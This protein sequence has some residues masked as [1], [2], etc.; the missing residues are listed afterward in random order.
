MRTFI[1]FITGCIFSVAAAAQDYESMPGYVDLGTMNDIYG[2][3]RVMINI[4]GPLMQI[5]SAAASASDDPEAAAIMQG[6]GGYQGQCVRH[7]R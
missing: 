6:A 2:E 4:G 1:A 5:L 7:G 3:P